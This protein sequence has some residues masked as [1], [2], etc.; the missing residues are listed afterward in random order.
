MYHGWSK[1]LLDEVLHIPVCETQVYGTILSG[2][3]VFQIIVY[4]IMS[5]MSI[6]L[7]GYRNSLDFKT[8]P[9]ARL[10]SHDSF[11]PVSK[12]STDSRTGHFACLQSQ[13]EASITDKTS[14]H[15]IKTLA[16]YFYDRISQNENI[17]F[18]ALEIHLFYHTLVTSFLRLFQFNSK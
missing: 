8:K 5:K 16:R 17:K 9:I 1:Q 10:S 11:Y 2:I 4:H 18:S 6:F 13:M 7:S 3:P 15:Q 14:G 12:K